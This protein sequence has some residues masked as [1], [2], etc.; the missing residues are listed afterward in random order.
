MYWCIDYCEG[1]GDFYYLVLG[2]VEFVDDVIGID[3]MVG[4]DV[5]EFF[6]Y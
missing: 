2:D 5:I 1:V 3:V 6:C 4:E